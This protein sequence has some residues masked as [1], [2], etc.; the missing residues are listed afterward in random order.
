MSSKGIF[1]RLVCVIR[2]H[3]WHIASQL[4]KSRS[5]RCRRCDQRRAHDWVP[6]ERATD[7]ECKKCAWCGATGRH[8]NVPVALGPGHS[9]CLKSRSVCRCCGWRSEYVQHT[10]THWQQHGRTTEPGAWREHRC[11]VCG[12]EEREQYIMCGQCTGTRVC[13]R[14][15]GACSDPYGR[16]CDLCCGA[17]D[18]NCNSH[19]WVKWRGEDEAAVPHAPSLVP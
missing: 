6:L 7:S 5:C 2:G 18:C 1:C 14:C 3:D 12:F 15:K 9:P 4:G 16:S 10:F 19:N 8:D 11:E 17:G 13:P